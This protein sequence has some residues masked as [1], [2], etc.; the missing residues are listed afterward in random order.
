MMVDAGTGYNIKIP[1][2]L[3]SMKSGEAIIKFIEDNPHPP[4][5]LTA[6]FR[7]RHPD[8]RVEYDIFYTSADVKMLDFFADFHEYALLLKQRAYFTPRIATYNC[9]SGRFNPECTTQSIEENCF[10]DGRYCA[11]AGVKF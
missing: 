9:H 4:V 5:V 10:G 7:M 3:V 6:D 2:M 8:D 1:S 11:I